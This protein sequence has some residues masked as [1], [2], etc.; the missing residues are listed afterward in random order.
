MV[1]NWLHSV[2]THTPTQTTPEETGGDTF[3]NSV[4]NDSTFNTI[5]IYTQFIL[6]M[7]TYHTTFKVIYLIWQNCIFV[8]HSDWCLIV[9]D[10]LIDRNM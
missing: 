4:F 7:A 10:G 9:I 5:L 3:N 2:T 1:E 8:I 6:N